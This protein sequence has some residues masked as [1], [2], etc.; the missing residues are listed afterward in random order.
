[1]Y[2]KFWIDIF[3]SAYE[4]L[5]YQHIS[6]NSTILKTP[7]WY[8]HLISEDLYF[9]DWYNKGIQTISDCLDCTGKFLT[10][11]C[12]SDDLRFWTYQF[13]KLSVLSSIFNIF[14]KN[15]ISV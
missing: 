4:I 10:K 12:N 6:E 15:T 13:A 2:N 5:K 1:M 8:N 9:T 14:S 3:N 7:I 11:K